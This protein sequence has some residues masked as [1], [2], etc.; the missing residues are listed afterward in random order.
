MIYRSHLE[1]FEMETTEV[2]HKRLAPFAS[3]RN[4]GRGIGEAAS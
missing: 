1:V 2:Q 3:D 4:A